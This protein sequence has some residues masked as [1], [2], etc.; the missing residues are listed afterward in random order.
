MIQE[1]PESTP[2][3]LRIESRLSR[4]PDEVFAWLSTAERLSQWWAVEAEVER[5]VGGAIHLAWPAM[6]WAL[7]G[8]WKVFDPPRTLEMTWN[9]RHQPDLPERT[10][11]FTL[12]PGQDEGTTRL[13]LSHGT[14]G[15]GVVEAEDRQSHWE[16]WAHFLGVLEAK[17]VRLS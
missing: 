3:C 4:S 2:S 7:F 17:L 14:Y 12:S 1:L 13:V 10:V 9:W 8:E 15:A 6:G 16:G 5:T 11:R